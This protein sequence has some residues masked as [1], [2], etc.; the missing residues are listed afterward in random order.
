M[1]S[2]RLTWLVRRLRRMYWREV[3]FRLASVARATMRR[4][5]VGTAA[6]VPAVRTDGRFGA[7]WC[8]LPATPQDAAPL[9]RLADDLLAGRLQVFG[10]AVPLQHDSPDW[11]ADPV[12]GRRLPLDFGLYLDFRHIAGLDIK[13][14]WEVNRLLWWVPLAQAWAAS[15]EPRHL[16]RLARLLDDWLDTNPYALG[17]NWSSPVEH[18]IRLINWSIVWHL[19]GGPTSPMFEGADGARRR[20]RWLESIYQ[21]M[22]FAADNYSFY[23]SAD[24]HLI[25]EAAGVF[26]A[27]HTWDLWPASKRM[28]CRAKQILED[29]T[30]KQFSP[31]GVNREQ[32]LC[33]HKFSLQF[34]L[35][36][37]LCGHVCDD[38]FSDGYWQR[39]VDAVT[40]LGALTDVSGNVPKFGDSDDG[41]VWRL[42][43]A[44]GDGWQ[45]MLAM[46][47]VL[48]GHPALQ[49][50]CK[51]L[52]I[53]PQRITAW[54]QPR[55][56]PATVT[57]AAGRASSLPSSYLEGGYALLGQ[58][59]HAEDEWRVLV[60]CGPL[61]YN[62]IAGHAHADALSVLVS[63]AGE[64]LLVDPGTYCYNAAPE[65]RHFFRSTAAHNTLVVDGCDQSP[66]GASF[67]WLRDVCTT[68][69]A[70]EFVD[71]CSVVASHD[72]YLRLPD[73]V[74]HHRR[75]RVDASTV[76]VDDWLE[77]REAHPVQLHWHA[78]ETAAL[79]AG[80]GE[81]QW[82]VQG[83]RVGLDLQVTGAQLQ[84]A[85]VCGRDSPPQGWISRRF[86]HLTAAAVLE[87]HATLQPGQVLTTTIARR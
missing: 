85:V 87:I 79:V 41:D 28:R 30:R 56:L 82:V 48:T 63:C 33:Y 84:A 37:A 49:A 3:P 18:G 86:Y 59:L 68:V 83:H 80:A 55:V 36:S 60:D 78:A 43:Q 35:A 52:G 39:L 1:S 8:R 16:D 38:R 5:G 4:A 46:G 75:V 10:Q 77:C 21:H 72:G 65:L 14:L 42:A 53:D 27:A 22:H 81:G 66:Y 58:H 24:N 17:P 57:V 40:F 50:K 73:P 62:R 67:L 71:G 7:P 13:F 74:R 34:L 47:A 76:Q 31:D 15:G 26:V 25:G 32:A 12:S 69:N 19:I 29:E 9:H 61:G 64:E 51:Q 45:E 6:H 23:S 70:E 2:R 11:L 44:T 20:E 54:L